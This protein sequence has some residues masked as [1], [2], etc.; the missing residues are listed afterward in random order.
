MS[1]L[2]VGTAPARADRVTMRVIGGLVIAMAVALA[3]GQTIAAAH[4]AWAA[5]VDLSLLADAPVPVE[6]GR[7]V[8]AAAV[9]SVT[10]ATDSLS[11]GARALFAGSALVLGLTALIVGFALAWLVF[12][13]ASGRPFRAAVYRFS[14]AAGLA[15][16]LGPLLATAL[17]GF[18]SMQAA[19][20]LNGAVDG[21]LLVGFGVTSWGLTIP[22]V[23]LGVIALAYL[24]RRMESLHRETE[25]LV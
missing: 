15:L 5:S 17:S 2:A 20:E 21:I 12:A 18:A 23:G 3:A 13:A 25:L 10:L 22:I 9:E 4:Y 24:L 16:V 11:A 19:V 14:L 6:P 7:G 1:D 8:E